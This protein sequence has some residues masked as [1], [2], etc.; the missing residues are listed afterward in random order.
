MKMKAVILLGLVLCSALAWTDESF[1]SPQLRRVLEDPT[2]SWQDRMAVFDKRLVDRI[3]V[4]VVLV[5]FEDHI[6][7]AQDFEQYF[8][9]MKVDEPLYG[10]GR[11]NFPLR[12]ERDV[13][14]RTSMADQALADSLEEVINTEV[15]K[16]GN[17]VIHWKAID[18]M[19]HEDAKKRTRK[20][21][22]SVFMYVLGLDPPLEDYAYAEATAPS[23]RW[24]EC[25]HVMQ[26][27]ASQEARYLWIDLNAG[28]IKYGPRTHGEGLVNGATVPYMHNY[29]NED[30]V[31]DDYITADDKR[32]LVVDLVSFLRKSAEMLLAP[33]KKESTG[34]SAAPKNFVFVIISDRDVDEATAAQRAPNITR[35]MEEIRKIDPGADYD[36]KRV[37][38]TEL[39]P[40]IAFSNSLR[41]HT[42]LIPDGAGGSRT[43]IHQYLDSNKLKHWLK[44][45]E[46]KFR[47][48]GAK[49]MTYIFDFQTYDLMLLDRMYQSVAFKEMT[50]AIQSSSN[51]VHHDLMC[52]DHTVVRDGRDATRQVLAAILEGAYL[53][54]P[55]HSRW[56]APTKSFVDDYLWSIGR[57]P[58]SHFSHSTELSFAIKDFAVKS[59]L[60]ASAHAAISS[61][62]DAME[63]VWSR[64]GLE[65]ES[66][67]GPRGNAKLTEMLLKL[68]DS[69]TEL[70]QHI[71][72]NDFDA[73]EGLRDTVREEATRARGLLG[74]FS[75][76]I[77]S[78]LVCKLE[79]EEVGWGYA[80]LRELQWLAPS[81]T[82]VIMGAIALLVVWPRVSNLYASRQ[83]K[84]VL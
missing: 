77:S 56:I 44:G 62:H 59:Y 61:L 32:Q 53:V 10:I 17:S 68:Y 5:G 45:W 76:L 19:I 11:T 51:G 70:M 3:A 65:P 26:V 34:R 15:D 63:A 69:A 52:G 29:H 79:E 81:I 14:F 46:Q 2:S 67:I 75:K 39:E 28:P 55:L 24:N 72:D 22:A 50:I 64:Y 38:L 21:T 31:L 6:L 4:E 54:V 42:T 43:D 82:F 73:A 66:V 25:P 78:K 35:I 33:P 41:T 37:K 57:T 1:G 13:Y 84:K 8:R 47:M 27:G 60:Y 36:V 23:A 9:S 16:N 40:A 80:V 48:Y 58:F 20:S 30:A 12:I 18:D 49:Y 83:K 7:Y 74:E 71:S